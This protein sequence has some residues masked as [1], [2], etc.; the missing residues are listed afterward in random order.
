MP[1][2]TVSAPLPPMEPEDI[3]AAFAYL[4]ALQADDI[5]TA[6]AVTN[7]IGPELHRLLLDVAA[8]VFIPITAVDDHDGE[9]CAHSFLS[10]ALGRLLLELLCQGVCMGG[11]SGVAETITRFAENILT[12]DDADVADVLRRLEAAGVEQAM[13]QALEEHHR[14][15]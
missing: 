6:C 11:V 13:D 3:I 15:M 7:V 2:N 4:R 14:T 10:A 5:D 8:H 1:E 12:E 9:P